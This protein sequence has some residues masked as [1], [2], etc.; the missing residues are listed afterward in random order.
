MGDVMCWPDCSVCSRVGIRV[1]IRGSSEACP[2]A[3]RAS[4]SH[5]GPFT[6]PALSPCLRMR[7]HDSPLQLSAS[8]PLSP[9][10]FPPPR[11]QAP[12]SGRRPTL[13]A[14]SPPQSPHPGGPTSCAAA[15]TRTPH[16]ARPS[17]RSPPPSTPCSGQP[18]RASGPHARRP[19]P[20]SSS[21]RR[22][23]TGGAVAGVVVRGVKH[24]LAALF[25]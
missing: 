24:E 18:R 7:L 16:S 2:P 12:P 22:G 1:G 23:A 3:N 6:V 10:T 25:G 5:F 15:G 19:R 20:R 14:A 13:A 21:S 11:S 8:A 9:P 4:G 17:V